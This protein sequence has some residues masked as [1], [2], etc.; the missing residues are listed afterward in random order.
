MP[1]MLI[2]I[3]NKINR[4]A[5]YGM[6]TFDFKDINGNATELN[7]QNGASEANCHSDRGTC[8]YA[9]YLNRS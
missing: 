7:I 1:H 5:L 6:F 9:C 8:L 2:I 4:V 3:D